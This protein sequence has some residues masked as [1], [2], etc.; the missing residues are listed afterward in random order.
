MRTFQGW[1]IIFTTAVPLVAVPMEYRVRAGDSLSH[2][3]VH[4]VEGPE[5]LYGPGGKLE[6]LLKQNPQ[7]K[8]PDLIFPGDK[9]TLS[10][11]PSPLEA[12]SFEREPIPDAPF[13]LEP[14]AELTFMYTKLE[15]ED[16]NNQAGGSFTSQLVPRLR[17]GLRHLIAE[18]LKLE[19]SVALQHTQWTPVTTG[20]NLEQPA[21]ST[22]LRA[23]LEKKFSEALQLSL[24]AGMAQRIF[25]RASVIN[26][27]VFD[28]ANVGFI[29]GAVDGTFLE[30][31]GFHLGIRG[32]YDHLLPS[33]A[34]S[35]QV[36]A[37][38][39]LEASVFL[40]KKFSAWSLEERLFWGTS[41]QNSELVR[42]KEQ[43]VG[44]FLGGSYAF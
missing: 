16:L 43:R 34:G 33:K 17:V 39:D 31:R 14:F 4:H 2:I 22:S 27:Y 18:D 41:Q 42:Q 30:K 3:A 10:L 9:I 25:S 23:G 13:H 5:A 36:D 37:G 44:L 40:K 1:I 7:I 21:P 8:N 15:A 29:G 26:N 32:A 38:H 35:I 19:L 28:P 12:P 20:Q 6:R 11:E 24:Y